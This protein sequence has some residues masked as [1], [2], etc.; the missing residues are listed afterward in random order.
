MLVVLSVLCLH[1]QLSQARLTTCVKAAAGG[2]L[3]LSMLCLHQQRFNQD[4]HWH[5]S[6]VG[7]ESL[8]VLLFVLCLHQ[9]QFNQDYHQYKDAVEGIIV[10]V[11]VSDV[12]LPTAIST[13]ITTCVKAAVEGESSLQLM[14]HHLQVVEAV[15]CIGVVLFT[16][17]TLIQP[18]MCSCASSG[19]TP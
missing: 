16:S 15:I 6:A 4:C 11:F 8:L 14:C 3:V 19:S 10:G 17:T 1:L 9:Q 5:K 13:R 18:V 7:G 2:Q 12:L